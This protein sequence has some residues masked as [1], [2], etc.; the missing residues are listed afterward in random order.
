MTALGDLDTFFFSDYDESE[1]SIILDEI[2]NFLSTTDSLVTSCHNPD[3]LDILCDSFGYSK[4]ILIVKKNNE[5]EGFIPLIIVS[6]LGARIVSMPHFSY[7]GYLG[8]KDLSIDQ[9]ND[10]IEIIKQKYGE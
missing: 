6:S 2:F 8:N 1:C 3:I 10:L 5:F 7:G 9:H 4:D